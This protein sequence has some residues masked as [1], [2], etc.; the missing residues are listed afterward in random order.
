[1]ILG[2]LLLSFKVRNAINIHGR[3][4][5]LVSHPAHDDT[6]LPQGLSSNY[7]D[8]TVLTFAAPRTLAPH[9]ARFGSRR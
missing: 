4:W 9:V 5:N 1:M 2:L 3:E 8:E 7:E 6:W